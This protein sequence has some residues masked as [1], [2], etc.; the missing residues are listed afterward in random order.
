[1]KIYPEES[2]ALSAQGCTGQEEGWPDC[3]SSHDLCMTFATGWGASWDPV[4]NPG[5]QLLLIVP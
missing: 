3:N 2:G 1:M 5:D 4:V